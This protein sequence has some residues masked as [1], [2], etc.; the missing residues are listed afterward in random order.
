MKWIFHFDSLEVKTKISKDKVK[1]YIDDGINI[2]YEI[3]NSFLIYGYIYS[4]C[5]IDLFLNYISYNL[6][7]LEELE[8]YYLN[9]LKII[10]ALYEDD[11]DDI[12][13]FS[14]MINYKKLELSVEEMIDIQKDIMKFYDYNFNLDNIINQMN[15]MTK[16][17]C[18]LIG[19]YIEYKIYTRKFLNLSPD[20]KIKKI[21]KKINQC[22]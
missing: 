9:C 15:N 22:Y 3:D 14:F 19:R 11:Y 20:E 5:A 21:L 4:L 6:C 10:I 16:K 18:L 1:K 17:E 7:F 12:L 2:L 8:A 13:S